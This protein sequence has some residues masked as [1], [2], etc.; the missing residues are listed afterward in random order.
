MIITRYSAVVAKP[1]TI[2]VSTRP[3]GTGSANSA[4]STAGVGV[5]GG[6]ATH[7]RPIAKMNRFTA[8][9][10]SSKPVMSWKVRGR[11]ISHTPAPNITP[12]AIDNV[13]SIRASSVR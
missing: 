13:S 11:R 1:M 4:G 5:I 10:I 2:A 6:W 12:T 3:W 8:Y 7:R 9:D